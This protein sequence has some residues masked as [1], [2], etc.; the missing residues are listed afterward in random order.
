[1][2]SG[3]AALRPGP[4]RHGGLPRLA[5]P[6]RPDDRRRPGEPEDGAGRCGR[7]TTRCRS[8]KWVL[9]DGRLRL[10]PAAC[11]TTTRSSRAST[12]SSRWTC[13]CPA[14]RRGRRCSSTRSSSCTTRSSTSRSARGRA[15]AARPAQQRASWSPSSV[16]FGQVSGMTDAERAGPGQRRASLPDQRR[17]GAQREAAPPA[18]VAARARSASH[19]SGDTSG[20][21]GLVR[22]PCACPLPAERPYG[23]AT[24]TTSPTRSIAAVARTSATRSSSVV[25]DRGELT[26]HVAPR[27]PARRCAGR[28]GTTRRCASSC[29]QRCPASTTSSDAG[30][31][32]GCTR[33]TT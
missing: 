30:R 6:G 3:A 28:C 14:A 10:A 11:S 27:A 23:G 26:F 32:P 24:S 19:G 18:S 5:A 25:V 15:Q 29:A 17:P 7:S 20:F 31:T 8:R 2:T 21:G 4:L 13:T 9:V 22:R 1:M 12:T 33:S 16:K